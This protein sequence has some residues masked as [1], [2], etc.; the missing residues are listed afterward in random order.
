MGC[1]ICAHIMHILGG[2]TCAIAGRGSGS[3]P[4]SKP[5]KLHFFS[6]NVPSF[7]Q[8]KFSEAECVCHQANIPHFHHEKCNFVDTPG[9]RDVA[10]QPFN[11]I[12]FFCHRNAILLSVP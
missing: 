10:L 1:T 6:S 5:L 11:N 3:P 7:E 9:N 8:S 2:L 12:D 4:D